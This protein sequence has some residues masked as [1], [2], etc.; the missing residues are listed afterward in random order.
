MLEAG[1][2]RIILQAIYILPVSPVNSNSLSANK[3]N[4]NISVMKK[5]TPFLLAGLFGFILFTMDLE[6]QQKVS[7][8]TL[9]NADTDNDIRVLTDN[10][11]IDPA[12]DGISLSIRADTE[13]AVVGSVVF[14]LDG[15]VVRTESAA[16]YSLTG[17]NS[18]DFSPMDISPGDHTLTATPYSAGGGGGTKGTSLTI[19]LH[20]KDGNGEE[21]IPGGPATPPA[22]PGSGEV[23]I[24]GELMQWHKVTL[25]INGPTCNE[26]DSD[27][28]PFLDIRLE[29]LFTKGD[30]SYK[31]PGYF[32]A[33]GDAANTGAASGNIWKVHFAPVDTGTWNYS[34]S[35]RLGRN[36]AVNDSTEAGEPLS[37]VDGISGTFEVSP[38]KKTGVDLRAHGLLQYVGEHYLRFAGTG[39]YF[40][41]Q[42]A[43]AP[44]NFLA[45]ADFDG[46]FKNDGIKDNLIKDWAPHI[47]DWEEG[48]PVWAGE[49][50]KGIIGAVNYLASEG[51]NAFSFLTMNID[52]DDRNVFPYTDYSQRYHMDVSKLEQWEIV[53]EHGTEKGMYLHFKTQETE[54]ETMLDG[55]NLGLQRRLYYRELI[56][57]FSHHLALNWNLGE[58][59]ND[60]T[61]KQRQDI[62]SYFWTHDPYQHNI[63][64]HNG[65]DPDDMLGSASAL[66][67]FSLQ[68]NQSDFSRVHARV[69]EWVNKSDNAGKPW[70]VACDEPGDAQHALV[71]DKDNPTHDNARKNGLWGTFMAGGAGNEWYFGYQHDQSDL[72][73]NDFRSRDKWWDQCR[74]AHD[75]YREYTPFREMK[76][77]DNLSNGKY[78][79]A[80]PGEIYVVFLED[81]GNKTIALEEGIYDVQWFNPFTGDSLITTEPARI[82]GPGTKFLGNPPGESA[83]GDWVALVRK[84]QTGASGSDDARLTDLSSSQGELEPEFSSFDTLYSLN[85]PAGE[86]SLNLIATPTDP[87]ATVLGAGLVE[88]TEDTTMVPVTV[89]SQDSTRTR[90]YRVEIIAEPYSDDATLSGLIT[91]EGVLEPPFSSEVANYTLD[92]P[93]GIASVTILAPAKHT[94]ATVS[95]AGTIDVSGGSATVNIVVTAEDGFTIRTYTIDITVSATASVSFSSSGIKM[96]PNPTN[97]LLTI[98]TDQ[99]EFHSIEI[100]TI[101]GLCIYQEEMEGNISH[102]DMSSF[103]EGIY[104]VT[105]ISNEFVIE[106]KI[107]KI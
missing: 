86:S 63:V 45:Y 1:K 107:L 50:G 18:G 97:T 87:N 90:V 100:H 103:K 40:L 94:N 7:D 31:I 99:P 6:A 52:G 38:S 48:D 28:N 102:I 61:L 92:L 66:T 10:D 41:K 101:T 14:E 64:I 24:T 22:D 33:D 73:C 98:E 32:A 17:D 62:A 71:P 47:R 13:P 44:E 42:G 19:S 88:L 83:R 23:T 74:I 72:T 21:E 4:F 43:D 26:S 5:F 79:F 78:C 37:P 76:N 55:G 29:A 77:H 80:K 106:K 67:G 46:N 75:F 20:M 85:L 81:G 70:V 96:Y 9:I 82:T 104:F 84:N 36:V 51:M 89:I 25:N 39:E 93:A 95:G 34:L 54:N 16:P 30:L 56:A 65:K 68:T 3:L 2:L 12:K 53:F 91:S 11:T 69:L 57:R 58:E 49:K 8:L 35:M 105:A 15:S 59:I 27:P 60:L